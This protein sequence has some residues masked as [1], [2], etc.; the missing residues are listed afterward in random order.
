MDTLIIVFVLLPL[1]AFAAY[2]VDC[3]AERFNGYRV[4]YEARETLEELSKNRFF[5]PILKDKDLKKLERAM[6]P[7]I[8]NIALK[9]ALEDLETG[10]AN[11]KIFVIMER[12]TNKFTS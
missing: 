7:L 5:R 10:G 2:G 8:I 6:K 4:S 12:D 9:L 3:L 11:S 1:V